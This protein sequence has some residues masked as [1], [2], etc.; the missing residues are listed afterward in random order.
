MLVT[1]LLGIFTTPSTPLKLFV[2]A[3][4][5]Y[6]LIFVSLGALFRLRYINRSGARWGGDSARLER[7]REL[8]RRSAAG[9]RL[10]S[11]ERAPAYAR[12]SELP[13]QQMLRNR[14]TIVLFRILVSSAGTLVRG[15]CVS[16]IYDAAASFARWAP[17]SA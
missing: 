3:I 10:G 6:F 9:A 1:A 13:F 8:V 14:G 5:W 11:A 12:N 15:N 4:I 7:G 2:F 16:R 17:R